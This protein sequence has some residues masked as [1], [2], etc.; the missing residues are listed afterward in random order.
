MTQQMGLTKLLMESYA[1]A[2]N[3]RTVEGQ[4]HWP[5]LSFTQGIVNYI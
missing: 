5:S 2:T 3:E 1:G 4:P